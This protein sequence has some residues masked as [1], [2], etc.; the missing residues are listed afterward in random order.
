MIGIDCPEFK[1]SERNKKNAERLG[2]DLAHY[3]SYAQKAKEFVELGTK[4]QRI[5]LLVDRKNAPDYVD[6]YGRI[7]A[8]V[9]IQKQGYDDVKDLRAW[10]E[11]SM[12]MINSKGEVALNQTIVYSGYCPVY[13]RFDFTAK[14]KFLELQ[15]DAKAN[16]RGLW[17]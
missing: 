16:K 1:D 8:R 12:E 11:M 9:M 14:D 3:E 17:K 7:L 6:K 15:Q 5:Y 10:D 4:G 2:I 13:E